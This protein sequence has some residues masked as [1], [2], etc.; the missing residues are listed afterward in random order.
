[1]KFINIPQELIE[2]N[3][4]QNAN[5][6]FLDI[7]AAFF[8]LGYIEVNNVL[9]FYLNECSTTKILNRRRLVNL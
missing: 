2:F 9:F 3:L 8:D 4:P 6:I 5:L 1:M 7:V